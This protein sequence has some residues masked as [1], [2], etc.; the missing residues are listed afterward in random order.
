M[1]LSLLE[2]VIVLSLTAALFD[3]INFAIFKS[4]QLNLEKDKAVFLVTIKD[5]ISAFLQQQRQKP[6]CNIDSDTNNKTCST[7][8]ELPLKDVIEPLHYSNLSDIYKKVTHVLIKVD[9]LNSDPKIGYLSALV[10]TEEDPKQTQLD[11]A[12]INTL[13]G[14]NAGQLSTVDKDTITNGRHTFSI[15]KKDWDSTLTGRLGPASNVLYL[16]STLTEMVKKSTTSA[17]V[18]ITDFILTEANKDH[19]C[20]NG[21]SCKWYPSYTTDKLQVK[22]K[23]TSSATDH[24]KIELI[25]QSK[26]DKDLV[27]YSSTF[28]NNQ[29]VSI[30]ADTSWYN[31]RLKLVITP[32]DIDN[33]EGNL[34]SFSFSV[35]EPDSQHFKLPFNVVMKYS[36][37][38]VNNR[39]DVQS[40]S[41]ASGRR[42][43]ITNYLATTQKNMFENDVFTFL[44][45]ITIV[46]SSQWYTDPSA[47]LGYGSPDILL[48]EVITSTANVIILPEVT[49]FNTLM[50]DNRRYAFTYLTKND[51]YKYFRTKLGLYW[52]KTLLF[53]S[54]G[55]VYKSEK[56][57]DRETIL[58][59]D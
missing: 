58:I 40:G 13:V 53:S 34:E 8:K 23:K 17:D 52:D 12:R 27:F 43:F 25:S 11:T 9:T 5:D 22:F 10:F 57:P 3:V 14:P 42:L 20:L 26:S 38:D 15:S 45:P 44:R 4:Q 21:H 48:K 41:N 49:N 37:F 56:L 59:G 6:F 54:S 24:V 2:T 1:G 35:S 19:S 31:H 51:L 50:S 7:V 18:Q 47:T 33:N 29:S 28:F 32:Y 46:A 39:N 30:L 36:G 55:L 16:P